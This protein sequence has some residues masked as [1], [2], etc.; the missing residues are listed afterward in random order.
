MVQPVEWT[1]GVR[2]PALSEM[3]EEEHGQLDSFCLCIRRATQWR[4]S[5]DENSI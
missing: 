5:T 2:M 1:L 4:N 3:I